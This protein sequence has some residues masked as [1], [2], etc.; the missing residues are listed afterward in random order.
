ML[1]RYLLFCLVFATIPAWGHL[2]PGIGS[3][4]KQLDRRDGNLVDSIYQSLPIED[5][6]FIDAHLKNLTI[7]GSSCDKC[8]N[9]IRYGQSLIQEQPDK[10]HLISLLLFKYCMVLN[11]NKESKCDNVDFFNHN[12][13]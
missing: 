6:N 2:I 7:D 1:L 11:K 3:I 13:R 8:K 10:Q 5:L 12:F 9:K 4:S